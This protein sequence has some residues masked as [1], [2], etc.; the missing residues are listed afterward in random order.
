MYQYKI[1]VTPDHDTNP[2]EY[3]G[4]Q[5][6]KLYVTKGAA[7]RLPSELTE[8]AVSPMPEG[9]SPLY[10]MVHIGVAISLNDFGCPFDSGCCGYT[11]ATAKEVGEI[12]NLINNGMFE[13][14]IQGS[15]VSCGGFDD[16][17]AALEDAEESINT[18]VAG[19]IKQILEVFGC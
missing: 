18:L 19:D 13:Y 11:F 5:Y 12:N 14:V 16:E 4:D 15:D 3:A 8:E 10:M 7:N 1:K 6:P 17:A 2:F 9:A